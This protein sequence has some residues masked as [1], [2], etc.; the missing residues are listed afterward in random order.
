MLTPEQIEQLEA[1]DCGGARVLSAYLDLDPARQVRRAYRTVFEDLV[2]AA[3]ERVPEP[4]RGDLDREAARVQAWLE[5]EPPRAK[6]LAVFACE[7]RGLWQAHVLAVRTRDHLAVEPRPDVAPLLELV[8]EYERFAVALVDKEK[9]RLFTVFM[10]EIEEA[11]ALEDEVPGK[12]DQGGYS[13]A[14]FQ[15]HHD[16]HVHWHLRRVVQR[17]AELLRRRR[18]D[19]LILAGPAEATSE[20]Q[21][22]LPRA[23]GHR[24]AATI[25]AEVFAGE[26]EILEKALE[27]ERRIERVAEE[28]LLRTLL[29]AAGPAGRSTL[30]VAPTLDALWADMVQTLVVAE[31]LHLDGSECPNCLRL[32]P[33]T[34]DTCPTC[35]KGMEPVHDL[36]HRAVARARDQAARLEV[37]RGAA[38]RRLQE[39][40][41]GL[42]ALLRYRRPAAAPAEAAGR[43]GSTP[44]E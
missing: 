42:G 33:G 2:K 31:D 22:M 6:G 28:R 43:A 38:A 5:S 14:R 16:T 17:L 13:Q 8:D 10:G 23:L 4:A 44:G 9:A 41:S 27:V 1:F 18:F 3:R 7:P 25:P 34:V 11:E 39:V 37:V 19:R 32:M 35:G 30:G 29:D 26:A 36:V 21:R 40:G 12:H 24:L 20:L 15:R